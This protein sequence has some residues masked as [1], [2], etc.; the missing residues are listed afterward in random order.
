M[1]AQEDPR[2]PTQVLGA[3][4]SWAGTWQVGGGPLLAGLSG[5]AETKFLMQEETVLSCKWHW[6]D[7]VG[8]E[9]RE[10][11]VGGLADLGLGGQ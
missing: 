7:G 2:S 9:V 11:L 3:V 4:G 8:G 10:P 6:G 5:K 1:R